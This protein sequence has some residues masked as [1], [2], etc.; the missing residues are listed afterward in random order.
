MT[1]TCSGTA[2]SF[3]LHSPNYP[4]TYNPNEKCSWEISG[5]PGRQLQL[6]FNDFRLEPIN[7]VLIIHDGHSQTSP[8]IATLN[9]TSLPDDVVSTGNSFYIEF[10]S[11]AQVNLHG[12]ELEYQI[13]G[14]IPPIKPIFFTSFYISND[15]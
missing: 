4:S 7:D 3:T 10:I 11:D 5:P 14:K 9:G 6:K 12:F 2:D 15:N 13:K 1:A 8:I